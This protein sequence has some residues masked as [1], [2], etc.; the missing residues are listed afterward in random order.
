MLLASR[1]G[2]QGILLRMRAARPFARVRDTLESRCE[3]VMLSSR[4]V[5]RAWVRPSR[6]IW[7]T[8]VGV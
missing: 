1:L 4:P 2:W 6:R 3:V 5:W 7:S 8:M